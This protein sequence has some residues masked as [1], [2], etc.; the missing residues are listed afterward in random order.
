MT[1]LHDI[2]HADPTELAPTIEHAPA[3]QNGRR[4]IVTRQPDGSFKFEVNIHLE[5]VSWNVEGVASSYQEAF[6]LARSV[7]GR[8]YFAPLISTKPR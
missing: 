1:N 2:E 4:N 8:I 7:I 5:G 6:S 3:A